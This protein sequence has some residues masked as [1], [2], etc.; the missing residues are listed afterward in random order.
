M[1]KYSANSLLATLISFANEIG[2]LLK[3]ST[4]GGGVLCC[5][6]PNT[7]AS[8]GICEDPDPNTAGDAGYI[9]PVN[10]LLRKVMMSQCRVHDRDGMYHELL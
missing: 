5:K 8:G 3:S 1:I 9:C 4:D 6:A 7:P 2:N 10:W